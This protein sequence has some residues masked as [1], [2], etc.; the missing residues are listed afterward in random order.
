M[1]M[2]SAAHT[3]VFPMQ[4]ILNLNG[5]ARM[6]IPGVQGGNWTWRFTEDM[7]PADSHHRLAHYTW[8]YQRRA[9][10]QEKKYGDV[11]VKKK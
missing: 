5:K 2:R 6:N 9:D 10:Q 8:L 1:A 11:A 4:D 3:A 7:I